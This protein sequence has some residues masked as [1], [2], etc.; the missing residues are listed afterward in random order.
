MAELI[1]F[2]APE[3]SLYFHTAY[4]T[5]EEF[6]AGILDLKVAGCD[7]IVDDIGYFR[8]AFFSTGIV[9]QAAPLVAAGPGRGLPPPPLQGARP[10]T[11]ARPLLPAPA[12]AGP[13]RAA[14]ATPLLLPLPLPAHPPTAL[15]AQ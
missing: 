2:V 14:G 1:C 11:N 8:E 5:E 12:Y 3:A 13:P 15:A 9:A 4:S 6:A 10:A 7:I